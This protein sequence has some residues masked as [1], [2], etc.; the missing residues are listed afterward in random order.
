MQ[1]E[2]RHSSALKIGCF[3]NEN[4]LLCIQARVKAIGF[5][6]QRVVFSSF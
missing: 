6:L 3:L 2:V 1:D 5:G 4:L